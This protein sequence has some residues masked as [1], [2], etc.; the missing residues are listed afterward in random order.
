MVKSLWIKAGIISLTLT[1]APVSFAANSCKGLVEANCAQQENACYWV[2]S[3]K[4]SDG[5][6]VRGHCR[7]KAKSTAAAAIVKPNKPAETT[8]NKAAS[9][10]NEKKPAIQ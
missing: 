1:A 6:E 3:Y 4:R 7:T 9:Q 5:I 2:N 10:P 8:A